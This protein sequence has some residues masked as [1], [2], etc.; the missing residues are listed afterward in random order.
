MKRFFE[1]F[2]L[3]ILWLLS[4]TLI[5]TLWMNTNY[6]FDMLSAAHWE[7]LGTLQ[8]NR[9]EIKPDF[10][11]S[12][13]AALFIALI[14]LYL[15]VR[16]RT[17]R[18]KDTTSTMPQKSN[19]VI[20]PQQPVIQPTPAP[21]KPKAEYKT[22]QTFAPRPAPAI[23]LTPRPMSPMGLR[24]P[25]QRPTATIPT[26]PLQQTPKPVATP[27]PTQNTNSPE[28]RTALESGEYIIKK[29]DRIG[30]LQNP[31][32]AIAYDQSMWIIATKASPNTMVES[33]Q[34]LVTIF[35][36]TLGETA[37]DIKLRGFI[38]EPTEPVQRS[39]DLI[40]T[41]DN[42]ADFVKYVS[43]HK[44]IKPDDYDAELFEAFSTYIGT[45]TGYIGKS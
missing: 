2:L 24:P 14:G 45:V 15:I 35:D 13:I 16:P 41:F 40:I 6:G 19:I 25:T 3:G 27:Q 10:Y 32:V 42:T 17:K 11:I 29:C 31:T 21:E 44:N 36:D 4:I 33:I 39:D 9:S 37:N 7:Y 26:P 1:K 28:I 43:E 20:V 8:A 5:T 23:S 34:T 38:I 12:L 18:V 22:E 30:K